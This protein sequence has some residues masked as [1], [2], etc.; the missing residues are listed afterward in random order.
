[1][2]TRPSPPQDRPGPGPAGRRDDE[3]GA[4]TFD[5]A[6]L[7]YP[8][9]LP[10][11]ARRPELLETLAEHQVVVVAGETGSGKSTQLPKLCLELGRGANGRRIGHTQPRRLAAR[12]VAERIADE[13]GEQLGATI[14]Y[15]V[16]FTDVV[17]EAT[18]VKVMTDGILLNEITRDRRLDRYDTIIVDEA[19]ER[20]LNID[21]LLGYLH[22]LLPRRSDLRLVITSATID[23]ERFADHF[24]APVVEVTGRTHPVELRYRPYGHEPGDGRDQT[25]AIVDAVGELIGEGPGDVLVFCSGQREI[26]DAADALVERRW[27]D[28]EVLP[29][30]ARLTAAEQHRVFA[31]HRGRRIVVA[32][33]VAET[34]I[35]V[36]GVRS[37]VDT[38]TARISRYSR[39]LKVQRLPIEP[40]SVAS[41]D[42]RAGRCGRV[43]PG[44]CVRLYDED[45]LASRPAFTEPE[46][47]RTDLASVLLRMAAA[48][49]GSVE[50]FGFVEPPDRRDVTDGVRLLE[51]LGAFDPATAD[52]DRRLTPLGRRLARLPVDP[53]LGRMVLEGERYGCVRQ[54]IIV[55]AFLTIQDP[56]ERP[57]EHRQRADELHARFDA[58]G[59]D[60]L[61]IVELW[62]YLREARQQRSG[63]AFRRL[64]R[65]EHLHFLRIREW[66]DLDRQLRRAVADL[67]IEV[68]SAPDD[69]EAL[70]RSVLAGLLSQIGQRDPRRGLRAYRGARDARFVV[71]PGSAIGRSA[72][73]WVMAAELVETSQ[74]FARI[75]APIVPAWVEDLGGHLLR[76]SYSDPRWDA[77]AGRAVTD[78]R[79]TL[80]GLPIV[81]GRRV[82]Y[83]RVDRAVAREMFVRHALVEGDGPVRLGVLAENRATLEEARALQQRARHRQALVDDDDLTAFYDARVGDDV[84]SGGHFDRWW[85]RLCQD[86]PDVLVA[87]VED[88]L[89]PAAAVDAEA[90]PDTWPG[91]GEQLALE[92]LFDP[93]APD[94]G[95]TVHVPTTL[96]GRI[97]PD[98]LDWQVPGLRLELV[99]EL[100]RTLPKALRR[101]LVPIPDRAAELIDDIGPEDGPIAEVLAA[102]LRRRTGVRVTAGDFDPVRLPRHL[103]P[104]FRV[105]DADG[106]VRATGTDLTE[107]RHRLAPTVRSLVAA[108]TAGLERDG[109]TAWD[110]G[111]LPRR[112]DV[113]RDGRVLSGHP[114]LIDAGTSVAVRVLGSADAQD[115]AMRRG[116]R[117]LVWCSLANPRR[118]VAD[119]AGRDTQLA[120]AAHS[121]GRLTDLLDDIVACTLDALIARH[122]GP[123]WTA[124]GFERLRRAVSGD[125]VVVGGEVAGRVASIVATVG[126]VRSRLEPLVAPALAVSV[127]DLRT[128]LDRLVRP[129]FVAAAGADG[130][131]LVDRSARGAA[132]RLDRLADDIER[133]RRRTLVLAD[134]ETSLRAA[135]EGLGPARAAE[136]EALWRQIDELRL[137]LFAQELRGPAKVSEV[138]VQRAIAALST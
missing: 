19:H 54:A 44:I 64:C 121:P 66:H 47:L 15:A 89:G 101:P 114:A 65:D 108:E 26:H 99:T 129:G 6:R 96:I 103:R 86:D 59:S 109:L 52:P 9:E 14:G 68:S 25:E 127:A 93:T 104:T 87:T 92:Y 32:T 81:A 72:P 21:F 49:L 118:V 33:N 82:A 97:E 60:V 79:V 22:G 56:R 135:A 116:T 77:R 30:Y 71:A 46:I 95:V 119:T 5:P 91:G 98:L 69:P 8:S 43:G 78:E 122:G 112:V 130:L 131:D 105:A 120:L 12:S 111:D 133:D 57:A 41:A 134:L 84:T 115:R 58:D 28:T 125:L 113:E 20:S 13:M 62:R 102:E 88:L 100:L 10:V 11:V 61:A 35:T 31:P 36:P 55:A 17:S 51:E 80:F 83:A 136:V 132:L 18:R 70:H 90:F 50:D 117:R 2:T 16:R 106:T 29:L 137:A 85:R 128:H 39:R 74:L 27:P 45:D 124:E 38:G 1:M 48:G 24:G 42:Q 37:V 138:R 40:I 73:E 4:E 67:G 123:A 7:R 76:R 34:S 126:E 75:V 63:N 23:T 107:L 53:R 110:L 94:D 3:P